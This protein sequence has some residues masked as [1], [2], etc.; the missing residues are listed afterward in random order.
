VHETKKGIKIHERDNVAVC[1]E[2]VEEGDTVDFESGSVRALERIEKGHKIAIM[3]IK[4]GDYVV[5][6]G[7]VIGVAT[8]QIKK[9]SHVHVHNLKSLRMV[10]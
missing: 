1:L 5:K 3:N 4:R 2:D 8:D 6:Y 9:G 7:E 10:K